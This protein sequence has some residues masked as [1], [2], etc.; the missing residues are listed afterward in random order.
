M[1]LGLACKFLLGPLQIHPVALQLRS[2]TLPDFWF[3]DRKNSK[4][5]TTMCSRFGN[6]RSRSLYSANGCAGPADDVELSQCLRHFLFL[7]TQAERDDW[8]NWN[9]GTLGTCASRKRLNGAKRWNSWNDW[10]W[11][12]FKIDRAIYTIF[13]R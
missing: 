3:G 1:G 12:L 11:L 2:E 9:F 5:K 6:R 13:Y 4:P 7:V 8:N 10:N